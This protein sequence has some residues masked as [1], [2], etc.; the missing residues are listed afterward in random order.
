MKLL[1]QI[2]SI[3]I[4]GIFFSF[5]S[6]DRIEQPIPVKAGGLDWDLFPTGDS[7][8]YTWPTWTSNTNT[9][10]NI[11]LEDYTGHTCT[12]CPAAAVI[13]KGLEDANPGR[14]F[15]A[16]IHASIG[17]SF[18]TISPP[19]FTADYTTEEGDRYVNEI[20]SFFGNP[21]GTI[22]RQ[23][24]GLGNTIWFL[25]SA[26]TNT[27]NSSLGGGSLKANLQVQ[28][29]YYPQTRGLFIHTE[30]EFL[31]TLADEYALV[32]YLV[33]E[34]VV[35]PQKLANGTTEE[36]YHHHNILSDVINGTWGNTISSAPVT[37]EKTYN[38]FAIQLPDSVN[39][40][41]YN[42]DN[43]SLITYIYNK[44]SYEIIQVIGTEL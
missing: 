5:F 26:W 22:N 18:Q 24:G 34:S 36:E 8:N 12:N 11:L 30:C 25:S 31:T 10:Q 1:K 3:S 43:L 40:S 19:E 14:V 27:T 6:C 29:N 39:D 44:S 32:I 23:G 21:S 38:D 15:I 4:I 7:A 16:S 37:G 13:A 35:S 20:P 2:I 28:T 9:F 41:T 42:T 17:N 33:R